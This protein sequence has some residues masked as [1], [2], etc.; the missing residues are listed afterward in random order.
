M[1]PMIPWTGRTIFLVDKAHIDR[2][3]T[4]QRR[5]RIEAANLGESQSEKAFDLFEEGVHSTTSRW[6]KLGDVKY[7]D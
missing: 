3:G 2:W 4:D 6:T 1:L 7:P 5:Q